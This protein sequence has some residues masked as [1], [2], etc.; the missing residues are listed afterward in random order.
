M[1]C[2]DAACRVSHR[3]H[4]DGQAQSLPQD[5]FASIAS[6]S[7]ITNFPID[8]LLR[9]L[10]RP[11]ILANR[12]S[13][14]PR[15]TFSP[16]L[17][18]VPRWR[19]MIVPPGTSCPPKALKPSRCAF[20]SRPFREVPCPFLCAINSVPAYQ[21]PVA[22]K[23][24]HQTNIVILSQAKSEA[25]GLA[26][27]KGPYSLSPL[28]A[29][30]GCSHGIL[31]FSLFL[32]CLFRRRFLRVRMGHV[33]L[34]GLP[35]SRRAVHFVAALVFAALVRLSHLL[36][37]FHQ[38][39]RFERLPVKS[40]LGDADR[41]VILPVSTQLLVLLLTFVMKD[42]NFLAPSLLDNLAGYKRARSRSRHA[43]RLGRNRQHVAELD[44]SVR[45][46]LRFHPDHVARCDT[47]LLST[48]ADHRVHKLSFVLVWG[49]GFAPSKPS[50]ARQIPILCLLF[51]RN[52]L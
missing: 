1:S 15:P 23:F 37:F 51:S 2:R 31:L 13:S 43:A 44:L 33:L 20:E 19:T 9:N 17:T 48:C 52:G 29:A 25:I 34:S 27:S 40:N 42:Q 26:E 41:G 5:Y 50:A 12:V 35:R 32:R 46:F 4:K 3:V 28:L 7:I 14:L 18:R 38:L 24:R 11:V 45:V 10:M 39:G 47:I 16:G 8:P 22:S 49:R 6:G 30:A 36:L 21:W